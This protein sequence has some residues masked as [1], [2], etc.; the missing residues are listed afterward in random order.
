MNTF[1]RSLLFKDRIVIFSLLKGL[2]YFHSCFKVIIS[3]VLS[4]HETVNIFG[5]LNQFSLSLLPWLPHII[6]GSEEKSID[7]GLHMCEPL[8]RT[9]DGRWQRRKSPRKSNLNYFCEPEPNPMSQAH[10]LSEFTT[11][12]TTC[13]CSP[14]ITHRSVPKAQVASRLYVTVLNFLT[15]TNIKWKQMCRI[16]IGV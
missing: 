5:K 14:I 16:F 15:V 8:C 7:T 6:L 4:I 3:F 13:T 9:T 1:L 10:S 2:Q 12:H 11:L